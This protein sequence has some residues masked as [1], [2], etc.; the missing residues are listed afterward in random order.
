MENSL[1][2]VD[3][4]TLANLLLLERTTRAD[5]RTIQRDVSSKLIFIFTD[6]PI[7][8]LMRKTL[9][10]ERGTYGQINDECVGFHSSILVTYASCLLYAL[11]G[12]SG[13]EAQ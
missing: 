3:D 10:D 5:D 9:P 8:E 11:P 1:V 13:Y 4:P 6:F 7:V 2:I 12:P